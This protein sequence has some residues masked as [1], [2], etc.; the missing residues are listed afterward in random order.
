MSTALKLS[1]RE[2]E[3]LRL[4]ACG[5]TYDEIASA[6][7]ITHG[8]AAGYLRK[9]REKLGAYD[10]DQAVQLA[11]RSGL[12]PATCQKITRTRPLSLTPRQLEVLCLAATGCTQKEMAARLEVH[13]SAIEQRARVVRAKL[14]VGSLREAVGAAR[15]VGLLP[16]V[17]SS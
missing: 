17:S 15:R 16:H 7:S 4:K 5:Y 1:R 2:L 9:A 6:L 13:R 14:G 8:T 3:V 11:R 12:I 10:S